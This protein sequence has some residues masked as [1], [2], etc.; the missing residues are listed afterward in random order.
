MSESESPPFSGIPTHPRNDPMLELDRQFSG[1]V[2]A[3]SCLGVSLGLSAFAT[4]M[5]ELDPQLSLRTGA[6]SGAGRP[7]GEA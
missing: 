1:G 6:K 2:G 4:G 7:V 3:N 5:F